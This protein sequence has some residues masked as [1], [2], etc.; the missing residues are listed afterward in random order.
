MYT[1]Q[2]KKLLI[3]NILD[4]LRRCSDR[5]HTL[6]QKDI[7]QILKNEYGMTADRKA[8]RRNLD[9]LI[10]FGYNIEYTENVRKKSNG[11]TEIICTDWYLDREFDDS[12]LRLLI[13]SLLFSKSIPP[14]QCKEL[15]EK[16]EGLSN[17]YF[18]SKVRHV[19]NLPEDMP[20]NPALFYN[21]EIID[22]AIDGG[23]KVEFTYCDYGTDKKLHSRLNS[24]GA[25]R[26]YVV[27]PY[28][29]VATNGRYYLIGNL[30][31]YDNISHYRLDRI[32]DIKLSD[33]PVKPMR[34]VKGLERGLN[35]PRHMAEH[36]YMFSGESSPV[37]LR[38]NKKTVGEIVDWF[39][40]SVRFADEP[41]GSVTA[42]VTV[43]E[44]AMRYWVL[45]HSGSVT[46][47][48]PKSLADA[49]KGELRS[50]LARYEEV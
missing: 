44:E 6:S 29:M 2:P 19:S 33:E 39:G 38:T 42:R 22:S 47:L 45:Q 50:A 3:M 40:N 12:E 35:L 30:D 10:D 11:E 25:P 36:I 46:V 28:Q 48:S 13:D 23:K 4:I 34:K 32:T 37:V 7:A 24:A 1:Q 15:I 17:K 14:S 49:V 20:R 9:D 8:I 27:N 16:I 43:N 41:D 18:S 5:N 26:K 21:I 31:K